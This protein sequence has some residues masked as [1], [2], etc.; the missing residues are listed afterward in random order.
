MNYCK[1]D[2]STCRVEQKFQQLEQDFDAQIQ[3]IRRLESLLNRSNPQKYR[4][5]SIKYYF[6]Q[7]AKLGAQGLP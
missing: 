3:E 4:D 7:N 5:M 2:P 6:D 1:C